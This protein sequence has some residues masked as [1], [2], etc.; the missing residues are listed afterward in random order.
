MMEIENRKVRNTTVDPKQI[1]DAL[2]ASEDTV[3]LLLAGI[4]TYAPD[5]MHGLA[6]EAYVQEAEEAIAALREAAVV[7]ARVNRAAAPRK[8]AG[9]PPVSIPDV[10]VEPLKSARVV[11]T[12]QDRPFMSV[13]EVAGMFGISK[14][15]IYTRMRSGDFPRPIKTG[16]RRIRWR[17]DELMTWS[18]MLPHAE[19]GDC[20]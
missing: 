17:T 1:V 14:S 11:Q 6:K 3:K 18:N 13:E 7:L 15:T 12:P 5:F 10:I 20:E 4:Q 8:T 19:Y 16:Q 9:R 2:V